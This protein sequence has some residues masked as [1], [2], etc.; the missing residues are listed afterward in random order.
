VKET[1]WSYYPRSL[2][3]LSYCHDG[4]CCYRALV[5]RQQRQGNDRHLRSWGALA[6][7][8][9]WRATVA[10]AQVRVLVARVA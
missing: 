5:A 3:S 9:W 7:A 2:P 10:E 4:G 1:Y 6:L 8:L